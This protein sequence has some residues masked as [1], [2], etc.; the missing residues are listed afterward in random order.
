[1]YFLSSRNFF[2]NNSFFLLLWWYCWHQL[3]IEVSSWHHMEQKIVFVVITSIQI[4][5]AIRSS[6][7]AH[8]YL[9]S[10]MNSFSFPACSKRSTWTFSCG[11]DYACNNATVMSYILSVYFSCTDPRFLSTQCPYYLPRTFEFGRSTY[12]INS[13]RPLCQ[14]QRLFSLSSHKQKPISVGK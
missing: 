4:I 8:K 14:P 7:S 2:A 3:R 10:D 6:L 12:D 13:H 5:F 9:N 11:C 1:V